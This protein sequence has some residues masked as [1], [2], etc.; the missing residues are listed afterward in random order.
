MV[1]LCVTIQVIVG[2]SEKRISTAVPLKKEAAYTKKQTLVI[3]LQADQVKYKKKEEIHFQIIYM[4]QGKNPLRILV[5]DT[6]VGNNFQ[7]K[8]KAGE[9]IEPN[10]GYNT[11]SPK[12]G[13]FTGHPHLLQPG[14]KKVFAVDVL[15]DHNYNLVFSN[16]FTRSG[17]ADFTEFKT[18]MKLPVDYPDKYIS[19]G[20][21]FPTGRPGKYLF[22]CSY[23]G[24]EQD[25]YWSF[26][27]TLTP[28][29]ASVE[30]LWIGQTASNIVEIEIK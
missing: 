30:H 24:T 4:N 6:F 9:E 2:G 18:Q 12:A 5:D 16:Q 26:I 25:K 27:G 23:H 3:Q 29:D 8:S 7:C 1:N 10:P 17:T 14:E 28:E 22:Q 20:K 19:A 21:I 15:V 11:W 13:V